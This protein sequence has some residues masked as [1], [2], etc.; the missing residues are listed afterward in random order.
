M[1]KFDLFWP[2]LILTLT[3]CQKLFLAVHFVSRQMVFISLLSQEKPACDVKSEN[4]GL[5]L[6]HL[7]KLHISLSCKTLGSTTHSEGAVICFR[8]ALAYYPL[9][10]GMKTCF[11]SFVRLANQ[12]IV[13]KD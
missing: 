2:S 8:E 6:F 11:Q 3:C 7:S 12:G 9:G 10:S 13:R 5:F 1:H 4:P